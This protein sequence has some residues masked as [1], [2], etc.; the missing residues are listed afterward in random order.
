VLARLGRHAEAREAAEAQLA[1]AERQASEEMRAV[2]EHDLGRIALDGGDLDEAAARLGTAL[3][4]GRSIPRA[5]AR[6][7]RAGALA[8][9][10]RADT[11]AAEMRAATLEPV[12]A[13][14]LSSALVP[15][16][17]HVQGLV[18]LARG[19][20]DEARR[21]FEEAADGWRARIRSDVRDVYRVDLGRPPVAGLVEPARELAVVERD[22]A[23]LAAV[24]A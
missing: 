4:H 24:P 7:L 14:D 15:L 21:R 10:G 23:A 22:L 20:R 17:A 16:L 9:L 2:A 13:A 5:R 8:R 19:D 11:A 18:A 6:L 1:I 3:E 12:T